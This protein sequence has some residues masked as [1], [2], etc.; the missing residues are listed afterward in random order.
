MGGQLKIAIIGSGFSALSNACYLA[1]Q[2]YEVEVFEKKLLNSMS[3]NFIDIHKK[4]KIR[5]EISRMAFIL[6]WLWS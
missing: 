6:L 4:K 3:L 5:K 1:K 2:G